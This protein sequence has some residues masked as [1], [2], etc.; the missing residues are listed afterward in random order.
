M[1]QHQ[2]ESGIS[3]FLQF[4][5]QPLNHI[6]KTKCFGHKEAETSFQFVLLSRK[7]IS[8]RLIDIDRYLVDK[9]KILVRNIKWQYK[10]LRE[11][12]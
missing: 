4:G 3:D 6:I 1:H 7:T 11:R 12:F 2:A 9:L 10:I 5:V 8:R